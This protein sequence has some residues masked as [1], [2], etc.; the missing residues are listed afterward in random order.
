MFSLNFS[1]IYDNDI[2]DHFIKTLE[3][4]LDPNEANKSK[5]KEVYVALEKRYVFTLADLD[6]IAPCYEYFLQR[7]NEM[8]TTMH[9][10]LETVNTDFPQYFEY[11]RAKQLILMKLSL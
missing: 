9:W 4:I 2:T 3:R 7:F 5:N 6:T 10:K 11:E 1:V 8:R